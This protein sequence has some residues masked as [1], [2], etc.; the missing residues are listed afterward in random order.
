MKNITIFCDGTW[1]H[2][3]QPYPTNVVKLARTVQP[4]SADKT[5]QFVYYDDGVGVSEG[6]LDAAT[7][8]IGGVLGKGL[9][10]KI[11]RAYEFLCLNYEPGDRI[12]V[13]G[14][15]RG[16]Y[17]ARSLAGMLR[18][19]WILKRENA[20]QIFAATALYRTRPSKGAPQAQEDEFTRACA[21]FRLRY[22]YPQEPFKAAKAYDP[23]DASSLT[24]DNDCAWIQF[25]GVWDT[26]GS[27]GI[28]SNLP[29]A[30]QINAKY[31]FYDTSLSTF[32]RSARHA[33]SIDERRKTFAPTLWDNIAALNANAKS[34][35]RPYNQRPYQQQW[36]PGGHGYVGGGGDDGGISLAPML[37]VAE[38]A[39]RAGLAF[40]VEELAHYGTLAR[41]EA[42]FATGGFDLGEFVMELV[43][44]EDRPGPA[45][46]DEVSLSTCLR[47]ARVPEYRPPPL[48]RVSA[49]E[50]ALSNWRPGPD[51]QPYYAP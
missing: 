25:V 22:C 33:L 44:M 11:A 9:D 8:L 20:S 19:A 30:P 41:P 46:F 4:N 38:G 47:F 1:Q 42:K 39:A 40:D 50:A 21:E 37:W 7:H 5:P 10:Y 31:H 48:K 18:W 13:F 16:A 3:D 34:D 14:F 12:F 36:F 29:F 2:L 24:P 45:S 28:P 26:V 51:P 49:V 23:N 17:T 35:G 6:V 15:S 43:G 27:L 32:V